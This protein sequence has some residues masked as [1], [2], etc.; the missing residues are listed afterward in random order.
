MVEIYD[1][2][3]LWRTD[4]FVTIFRSIGESMLMGEG[5]HTCL[6]WRAEVEPEDFSFDEPFPVIVLQ[7][8]AGEGDSASFKIVLD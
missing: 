5:N 2:I 8:F 6:L 4:F 1:N 7:F 3:L